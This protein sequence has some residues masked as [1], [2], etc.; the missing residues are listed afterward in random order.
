MKH[1]LL[2]LVIGGLVL[3]APML[4]PCLVSAQGTCNI[5]C[6]GYWVGNCYYRTCSGYCYGKYYSQHCSTCCFNGNCTTNCSTY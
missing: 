1:I 6:N 4:T 3:A 5:S 2:V